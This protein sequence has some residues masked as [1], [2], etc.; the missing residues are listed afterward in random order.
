MHVETGGAL[1]TQLLA[2]GL[3]SSAPY[4]RDNGTPALSTLSVQNTALST[5]SGP[6]LTVNPSNSQ[7]SSTPP[8]PS[9]A[10]RPTKPMAAPEKS[11]PAA[12]HG[13]DGGGGCKAGSTNFGIHTERKIVELAQIATDRGELLGS[14][15]F[16]HLAE[17]YNQWASENGSRLANGDQLYKKLKNVSFCQFCL[18]YNTHMFTMSAYQMDGIN[19]EAL[20]NRINR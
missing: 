20:M 15:H 17:K 5:Y 6:Q 18:L 4:Q 13:G 2:S 9:A 19:S 14:H 3:A 10:L 16:E 7:R 12:K 11:G 1:G 8:T